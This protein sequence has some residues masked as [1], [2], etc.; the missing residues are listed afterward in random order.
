MD[1]INNVKES[2]IFGYEVDFAKFLG[3][4]RLNESGAVVGATAIRNIWYTEYDPDLVEKSTRLVGMD[5][6]LA[7]PYTMLWEERVIN[8]LLHIA[9]EYQGDGY[10]LLPNIARR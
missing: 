10:K 3:G 6:D 8:S 7:D 9:E 5:V 2:P 4:K 1:D